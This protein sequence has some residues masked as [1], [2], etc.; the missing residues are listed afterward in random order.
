[1]NTVSR[2]EK[3]TR[4]RLHDDKLG[5]RSELDNRNIDETC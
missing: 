5:D 4:D 2:I 1:M 3:R